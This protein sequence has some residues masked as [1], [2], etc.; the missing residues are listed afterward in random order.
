MVVVPAVDHYSNNYVIPLFH[1]F[2]TN[3]IS[4]FVS[5]EHYQPKDIYVDSVSLQTSTWIA[6]YCPSK[7]TCGYSAYANLSAGD[8]QIYHTKN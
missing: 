1:P 5:P 6:I 2:S 3:H 7:A 4:I 8:H